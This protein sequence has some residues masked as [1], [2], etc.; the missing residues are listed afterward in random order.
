MRVEEE[1]YD[2]GG[3]EGEIDHDSVVGNKRYEGRLRET[4]NWEGNTLGNIKMK[5]RSFQGK[6]DPEA[7]LE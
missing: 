5:I 1:E 6:N 2:R 7:Y 4:R 3:F